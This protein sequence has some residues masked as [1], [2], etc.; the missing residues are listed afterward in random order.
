VAAIA[1][2]ISQNEGER[3]SR[4]PPA[5]LSAW[6]A[7]HRGLW[8]RGKYT[9]E[10]FAMAEACFGHAVELDPRFAAAYAEWAML[11][12]SEAQAFRPELPVRAEMRARALDLVQRAIALDPAEATAHAAFARALLLAGRHGESLAQADIA[13]GLA[14]NSS[15]ACG[16]QGTVRIYA[17]L[18]REGIEALEGA[19]RL[20]P[21]D[22]LNPARRAHIARAHYWMAEYRQAIAVAQNVIRSHPKRVPP[23][24]TL[25]ASLGQTGQVEKAHEVVAQARRTLGDSFLQP[26]WRSPAPEWLPDHRAHLD[27]GVRKAGFFCP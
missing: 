9:P 16:I 10:E 21:V 14:P 26:E 13:V 2:A 6:E 1:P 8:H 15:T 20:N 4:H 3:V 18:H 7:Y 12:L 27:E 17:G 5:S 23:H 19:L 11:L 22:P 25:V 24:L